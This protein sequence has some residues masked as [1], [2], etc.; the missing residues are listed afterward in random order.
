MFPMKLY[1]PVGFRQPSVQSYYINMSSFRCCVY[2]VLMVLLL[3]KQGSNDN[4]D[5]N[6]KIRRK[7]NSTAVRL[8][9]RVLAADPALNFDLVTIHSSQP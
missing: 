4:K 8:L 2:F 3:L 6:K 1:A 9:V 5:N 7:G